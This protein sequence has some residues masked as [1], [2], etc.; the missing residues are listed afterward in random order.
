[1]N[2]EHPASGPAQ[3]ASAGQ[4]GEFGGWIAAHRVSLHGSLRWDA[5]VGHSEAKQ[6]LRGVLAALLQ[7]ESLADVGASFPRGLLARVCP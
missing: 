1:M 6:E 4:H 2:A 7:P 5:I 3:S